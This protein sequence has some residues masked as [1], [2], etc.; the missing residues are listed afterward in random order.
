MQLRF[1]QSGEAHKDGGTKQKTKTKTKNEGYKQEIKDPNKKW[2]SQTKSGGAKQKNERSKQK[3]GQ[4]NKK[5][6][7]QTKSGEATPKI[8]IQTKN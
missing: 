2:R 4:P 5:L 7:I 1:F 8:R 6:R 3:V